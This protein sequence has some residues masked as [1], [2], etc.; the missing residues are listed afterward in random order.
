MQVTAI[1]QQ[2][3]RPDRYSVYVDEKYSFSLSDTALLE[4]RITQ[5]QELTAAEVKQLKQKS[6]DDKVYNL[7]LRYVAIRSR[8]RHELETYLKRKE[9]APPLIDSIMSRLE[10]LGLVDDEAF[11]RNWVENRRLL[12]SVS[13][14]RLQL[15]L[16]QK[17]VPDEVIHTVLEEDETTDRD[18]LRQLVERKRRQSKYQDATKLMQYLARQGYGYDDIKAALASDD[19]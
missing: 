14:R 10:Q 5:G 3:K 2:V 16:R 12:K 17:Y 7:A 4:S 19:D 11:A 9:A 13:R 8:S 6:A 15:E 1:K 18:T